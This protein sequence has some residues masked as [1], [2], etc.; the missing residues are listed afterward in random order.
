MI[1]QVDIGKKN[2]I[3]QGDVGRKFVIPVEIDYF[4]IV[5]I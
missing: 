3:R 1:R 5:S 4:C 2:T